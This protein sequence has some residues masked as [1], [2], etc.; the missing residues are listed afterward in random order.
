M[1]LTP[2]RFSMNIHYCSATLQPACRDLQMRRYRASKAWWSGVA[3]T[4]MG[5]SKHREEANWQALIMPCR[6]VSCEPSVHAGTWPDLAAVKFSLTAFQFT[7]CNSEGSSQTQQIVGFDNLQ[8]RG[9]RYRQFSGHAGSCVAA[10]MGSTCS[11]HSRTLQYIRAACSDTSG[12]MHAPR[13]PA[14]GSGLQSRPHTPLA[15][16]CPAP[17]HAASLQHS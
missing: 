8:L 13:H 3:L 4:Y 11:A 17:G 14:P 10:V 15:A 9:C 16:G 2:H 12:S 5:Q 7:T 6:T 1:S